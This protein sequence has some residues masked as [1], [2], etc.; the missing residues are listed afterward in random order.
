M[1]RI[2][3]TTVICGIKAEVS[4]PSLNFPKEGYLGKK[5]PQQFLFMHHYL[6]L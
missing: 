3:N 4:E 5:I 2:G 1:V 6:R